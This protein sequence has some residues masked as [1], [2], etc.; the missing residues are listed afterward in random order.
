MFVILRRSTPKNLRVQ[1]PFATLRVTGYKDTQGD[2]KNCP[3]FHALRN[4]CLR[5]FIIVSTCHVGPT[6]T[7]QRSSLADRVNWELEPGN[8]DLAAKPRCALTSL[9]NMGNAPHFLR[10]ARRGTRE[11]G[12]SEA[13][14]PVA[15]E[16]VSAC[17]SSHGM[18]PPA[19][20]P[21]RARATRA[22]NRGSFSS[23]KSNQSSSVA[24][25]MSTPAGR[26]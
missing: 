16:S 22:R 18:P 14:N 1:R 15:S 26:P 12:L 5:R 6:G 7:V 19:A 17:T 9:K 10:P 23:R 4:S 2:I 24:K 25:P 8:W 21:A 13:L 3:V 11:A 20:R